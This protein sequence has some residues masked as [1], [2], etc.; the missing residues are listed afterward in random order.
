MRRN[1][2]SPTVGNV[3]YYKPDGTGRDTYIENENGGF[4]G[5]DLIHEKRSK[6][7]VDRQRM[8]FGKPVRSKQEYF[9]ENKFPHYISDGSG[10]DFYVTSNDGG[11][12]RVPRW[13]DEVGFKFRSTLRDYHKLPSV[14]DK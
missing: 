10:R 11:N 7:M 2:V 8:R 1:I 3:V 4:L 12:V 14:R 6:S 9:P 5:K 13:R